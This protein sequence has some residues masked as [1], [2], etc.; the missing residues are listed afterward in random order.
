[1]TKL[2]IPDLHFRWASVLTTPHDPIPGPEITSSSD[3]FSSFFSGPKAFMMG[4]PQ[5]GK[6]SLPPWYHIR[7]Y[8]NGRVDGHVKY[9][10]REELNTVFDNHGLDKKKI[11]IKVFVPKSNFSV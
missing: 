9:P 3:L 8:F 2:Q 11:C 1:M 7:V 5:D 6:F 10:T 4:L